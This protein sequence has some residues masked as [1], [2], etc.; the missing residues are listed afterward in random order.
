MNINDHEKISTQINHV[1][2]AFNMG[3]SSSSIDKFPFIR[4]NLEIVSES[5][6]TIE[7]NSPNSPFGNKLHIEN[8]SLRNQIIDCNAFGVHIKL[9]TLIIEN[10]GTPKEK[11]LG[12]NFY[13]MTRTLYRHRRRCRHR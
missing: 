2:K 10:E 8:T 7:L 6:G 5:K 9:G 1:T 4:S 11:L 13:I 3:V 12:I